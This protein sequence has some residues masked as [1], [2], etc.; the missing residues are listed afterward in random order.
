MKSLLL[1]GIRSVLVGKKI[2][3]FD[4]SKFQICFV[5]CRKKWFL[6][7]KKFRSVFFT[8]TKVF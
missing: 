8:Q 1:K 7:I 4:L 3:D 5:V 6:E 2:L